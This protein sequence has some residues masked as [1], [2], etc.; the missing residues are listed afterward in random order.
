[1]VSVKVIAVLLNDDL[2][3]MPVRP[4]ILSRAIRALSG[5]SSSC[6]S[7]T[8]VGEWIIRSKY[9]RLALNR[10]RLLR[11]RGQPWFLSF[12]AVGDTLC[13]DDFDLGVFV[14]GRDILIFVFRD[15][16]DIGYG[17]AHFEGDR[18][19]S[20]TGMEDRIDVASRAAELSYFYRYRLPPK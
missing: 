15:N 11:N 13:Q 1:M 14:E 16:L 7:G 6:S 17:G 10:L 19:I 2:M 5:G 9:E 3:L 20:T 8:R 12:N 4:S 18:E